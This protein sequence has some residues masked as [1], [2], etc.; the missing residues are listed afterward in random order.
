VLEPRVIA[1]RSEIILAWPTVEIARPADIDKRIVRGIDARSC[2]YRKF[3]QSL[4]IGQLKD[5]SKARIN[6]EVHYS[7]KQFRNATYD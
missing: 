7:L 6:I 2:D 3:T 1:D 5:P 4:R